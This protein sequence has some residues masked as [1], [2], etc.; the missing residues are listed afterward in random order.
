MTTPNTRS[1][2]QVTYFPYTDLVEFAVD[3]LP[4]VRAFRRKGDQW[5]LPY[6]PADDGRLLFP[7]LENLVEHV[8]WD[9]ENLCQTALAE[10]YPGY[11][12]V[13]VRELD[14]TVTAVER[15]SMLIAF[16][17]RDTVTGRWQ[18]VDR[19]RTPRTDVRMF[20][21]R[22]AAVE[23]VMRHVQLFLAVPL[24]MPATAA[25]D[26]ARARNAEL[27]SGVAT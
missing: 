4:F 9:V 21:F 27:R 26:A 2:P 14:D 10:A 15:R 11:P 17:G 18:I 7:D 16:V 24:R 12:T 25:A 13:T 6:P 20:E 19:S 1:G 3:G 22:D 8:E 5:S 23:Y